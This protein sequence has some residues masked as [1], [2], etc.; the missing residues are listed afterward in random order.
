MQPVILARNTLSTS[1]V[2][3]LRSLQD[4]HSVH[5]IAAEDAVDV[6]TDG[7]AFRLALF[8][9]KDPTRL[10]KPGP[11][12]PGT[13]GGNLNG[14]TGPAAVNLESDLLLRSTHANLLQAVQGQ[15]PAFG[16]TVRSVPILNQLQ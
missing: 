4:N 11:A 1:V 14:N 10:R 8:Y 12:V 15:H 16:A 6:L 2:S 5:V 3:A 9:E 7:F 13:P